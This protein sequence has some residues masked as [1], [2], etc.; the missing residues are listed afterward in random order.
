MIIRSCGGRER[1]PPVFLNGVELQR[2]ERFKYLGHILR[3]DLAVRCTNG[4]KLA[5]LWAYCLTF[6]TSLL[7]QLLECNIKMHIAL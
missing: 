2:V 4:V 7:G 6:Y 5:I 3:Q 1:F